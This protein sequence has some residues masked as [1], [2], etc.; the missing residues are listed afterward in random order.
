LKKYAQF[1]RAATAW[2]CCLAALPGYAAS[3]TVDLVISTVS[4]A[5]SVEMADTTVTASG[6]SGTLTLGHSS[7]RPF[8][9]GASAT[10]QYAGFSKKTPSGL[11]LEADGVATFSPDDSLL[12]VFE[13]KSDDP[14]PSNEGTLHLVGG[15]GRFSGVSGECRYQSEDKAESANVNVTVAKC[16]WTYS[17][18][19][20]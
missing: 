10:I 2:L 13:R 19:Y 9:E 15:S 7:G 20:R 17:F 16:E 8:E 4:I 1:I 3:G 6:G 11:N 18:P 12:V 5:H 14:G